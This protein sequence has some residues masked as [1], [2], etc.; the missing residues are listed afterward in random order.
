M[1]E[2]YERDLDLNLLRVFL[3]V[4]E[5]GSVTAAAAKLYLTQP[6]VSAALRRLT[7]AIGEPLFAREGR[8]L[9]LTHRGRRLLA[10]V[11]PHLSAIIDAA[12]NDEPFDPASSTRTFYLG[13]SDAMESWLF[14]PLLREMATDAPHMR[15]VVKRVQF[16]TVARALAE[17]RVDM[18]V[19][20]ADE[21]PASI[22]RKPVL[23]GGFVCLFDPRH[24]RVKRR[25]TERAYFEHDHVIVSYNG[26]LRG[27][28]E[29]VYDKARRVRCSV[30]SFNNV[31]AV[32]DG[33]ALMATVPARVARHILTLRPHL[34]TAPVPLE[35]RLEG[36]GL[37]LLWRAADD[38]DPA[39]AFVRDRVAALASA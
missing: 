31:G 10:V 13:L 18:A 22:Q 9:S 20:V 4:A 24:A 29:D 7:R 36:T 39:A 6:A 11:G 28:I 12:V 30:P 35:P 3:V 25:V 16:R 26:D 17:Q 27:L 15:F 19:T 32:V 33:T 21:L 8:G 38:D 37:E 2:N 23:R 14:P 1:S 34:R 5:Q